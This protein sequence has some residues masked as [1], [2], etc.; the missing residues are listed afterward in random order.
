VTGRDHTALIERTR[1]TRFGNGY[2]MK[3]ARCDRPA[4]RGRMTCQYHHPGNRPA[5]PATPGRLASRRLQWMHRRG[6]LPPEL[7]NSALWVSLLPV[8]PQPRA[9][10]KLGLL[11]AWDWRDDQ[12]LA[13]A[14]A[15]REAR[16]ALDLPRL[17]SVLRYPDRPKPWAHIA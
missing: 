8:G 7:M 6:L 11:L 1:P 2:Q 13:W 3:C 17:E 16:K 12:P 14:R 5:L 15:Q 10:A 4:A 9:L